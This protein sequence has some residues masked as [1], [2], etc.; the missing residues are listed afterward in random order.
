MKK[1]LLLTLLSLTMFLMMCGFRENE[2][3]VFDDGELLTAEEE[4][5][6]QE[7]C[8]E[9]AKKTELDIVVVTT[10]DLGYKSAMSYADDFYDEG[11][12][13]YEYEYGSGVLFLI[14]EDPYS[15]EGEVYISTAGLG[16]L[17]IDDY[18]VET[19][20]DAGWDDFAYDR[21]YYN[22]FTRMIEK[23]EYIVEHFE[24]LKGT[25]EVLEAW[26]DGEYRYYEEF[27]YDYDKTG[28]EPNFFSCFI[29]CG[30]AAILVAG[31]AVLVM[32]G[33]YKNKMTVSGGTYF[34]KNSFKMNSNYDNFIRTDVTRVR[35]ESSSGSG[36]G[37]GRSGGSS[38]RSSG[39]R[40]HG[41]GGRRR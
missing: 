39:G 5:R 37:G 20:L 26:Y 22:C 29:M 30:G 25:E 21:E 19:I 36:G 11:K 13:G 31:I 23:T 10:S 18:D 33:T 35:I 1:R 17:Y 8:I 28:R 40:S 16:I 9:T 3:K 15:D 32:N 41:G 7:L 24:H 2:S 27:I 14:Y 4:E 34:R 6:L 38:H 12:Y